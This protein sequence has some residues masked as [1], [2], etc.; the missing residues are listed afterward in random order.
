[1]LTQLMCLAQVLKLIDSQTLE[2]SQLKR[3]AV[4]VAATLQPWL[5]V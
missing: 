4:Q 5:P 2:G 1:M 3:Q